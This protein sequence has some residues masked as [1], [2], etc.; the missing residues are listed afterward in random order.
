MLHY[1]LITL[2][3]SRLI[4]QL[5]H[6]SLIIEL[7]VTQLGVLLLGVESLLHLGVDGQQ[8]L[9]LP[10]EVVAVILQ[11][12]NLFL[13]LF[14]FHVGVPLTFLTSEEVAAIGA[15]GGLM[16]PPQCDVVGHLIVHKHIYVLIFFENLN[17]N[18]Y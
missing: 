1:L 13:E 4:H 8:A 10:L 2:D 9:K 12:I 18:L 6:L 11:V 3:E 14:V 5:G 16:I 15:D 17:F 7:C